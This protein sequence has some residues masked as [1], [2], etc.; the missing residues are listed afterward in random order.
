MAQ[1]LCLGGLELEQS[2]L[3]R[4][5]FA[6]LICTNTGTASGHDSGYQ[7]STLQLANP[8]EPFEQKPGF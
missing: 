5:E 1:S 4:E 2:N 3:D 8:D 6:Q 7:H